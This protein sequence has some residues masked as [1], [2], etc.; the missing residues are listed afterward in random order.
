[1]R[2]RLESLFAVLYNADPC[3]GAK[4]APKPRMGVESKAKY[5]EGLCEIRSKV[6]FEVHPLL[7]VSCMLPA[8]NRKFLSCRV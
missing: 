7:V 4:F 6:N 3:G 5:L 2:S 1:M 8:K